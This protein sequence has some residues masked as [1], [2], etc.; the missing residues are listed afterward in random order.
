MNQSF[1][2]IDSAGR[3][4]VLTYHADWRR[5]DYESPRQNLQSILEQLAA[6]D[7]DLLRREA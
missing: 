4:R 3:R 5:V 6:N 7:A 1:G 2:V